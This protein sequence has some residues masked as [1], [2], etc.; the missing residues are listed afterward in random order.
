[1]VLR[2]LDITKKAL[3]V[4]TFSLLTILVSFAFLT[5]LRNR[6]IYWWITS[7]FRYDGQRAQIHRAADG[8]I[9]VFSRQMKETTSR[10]P[11]LIDTIKESCKHEVS[12]FILDA[13]VIFTTKNFF[14]KEIYY[15]IVTQILSCKDYFCRLLLWIERMV[16]NSCLFKNYLHGRE[17]IK[18][19]R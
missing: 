1:M 11:D 5:W 13:E 7:N 4:R 10:F 18:I 14:T 15:F 9:R 16:G 2:H 17:E 6:R 12:T 3:F 19:P 8:S